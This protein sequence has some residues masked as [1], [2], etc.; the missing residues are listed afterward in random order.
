MV[1][2]TQVYLTGE[3]M[4]NYWLRLLIGYDIIFS[5]LGLALA[6]AVLAVE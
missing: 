4:A 3:G 1:Q 5:A 6:E 2:G